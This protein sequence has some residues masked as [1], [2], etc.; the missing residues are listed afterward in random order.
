MPPAIRQVRQVA[1]AAAM[2]ANLHPRDLTY[3]MLTA[4]A[5]EAAR[6]LD[7]PEPDRDDRREIW[8]RQ[9]AA[10][11]ANDLTA[12]AYWSRLSWRRAL[13]NGS[14]SITSNGFGRMAQ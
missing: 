9:A 5:D 2:I 7:A 1:G 11:D 4:S 14:A 12:L 10:R 6:E 13:E 3:G 8:A